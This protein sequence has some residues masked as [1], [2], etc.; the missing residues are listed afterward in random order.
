MTFLLYARK[1]ETGERL[2][3]RIQGL[4][5]NYGMESFETIENLIRRLRQPVH[6]FSMAVILAGSRSELNQILEA[7]DLLGSI[8]TIIILPDR[9]AETVTAALKLHPRYMSYADGDFLDVSM[10]AGRMLGRSYSAA[11]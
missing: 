4:E 6:G 11:V 3:E 1:D 8:R 7:G 5:L 10:V 2:K 9:K